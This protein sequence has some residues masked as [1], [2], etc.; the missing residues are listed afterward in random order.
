M[1]QEKGEE[2]MKMDSRQKTAEVIILFLALWIIFIVVSNI[3]QFDKMEEMASINNKQDLRIISIEKQIPGIAKYQLLVK[4][5][6]T[7]AGDKLTAYEVTEVAKII[8]V[9]CALNEDIG[10][11]PSL[12][13]GIMERESNFD[14][15][16]I[17]Y[18]RAYGLM[19]ITQT[20]C[21]I[22]L[23]TLGYGNFSE[24]LVLSPIINTEIGIAELIRLRKYWLE[25]DTDSFIIVTTSY[26]WGIKNTWYLLNSKKRANL[27]SLEYGKGILDL[28]KAWKEKGI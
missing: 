5:L 16:A 9:Q 19:Q 7:A 2:E 8:I 27:P 18:A 11:T 17:S 12:I 3:R 26:F 6:S 25:N 1:S 4:E 22:H 24:A 21:E 15:N 10:M 28:A 20:V 13:V 23:P 14:P